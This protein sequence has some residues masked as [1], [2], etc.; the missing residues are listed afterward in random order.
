VQRV[1]SPFTENFTY[2]Y[3]R[4]LEFT[5]AGAGHR[6]NPT[7]GEE[8]KEEETNIIGWAYMTSLTISRLS[9]D[10]EYGSQ[11]PYRK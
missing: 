7:I 9:V 10:I 3:K 11:C 6:P 2:S 4:K 1:G 8:E 5:D